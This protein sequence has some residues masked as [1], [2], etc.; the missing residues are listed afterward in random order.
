MTTAEEYQEAIKK[1]EEWHKFTGYVQPLLNTIKNRVAYLEGKV[2]RYERPESGPHIYSEEF[3]V[4]P[5]YNR[6]ERST[7]SSDK[8]AVGVVKD[9]TNPFEPV[10]PSGV[11]VNRHPEAL[12]GT[13]GGKGG[14]LGSGDALEE[15]K[16]SKRDY[17]TV[18]FRVEW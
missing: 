5:I 12:L 4:E 6:V 10:S 14:E 3:F 9:L 17:K 8:S 16:V 11:E 2:A 1:L 13:P 15:C 7:A 18:R